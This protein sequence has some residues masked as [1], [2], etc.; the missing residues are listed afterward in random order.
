MH[1][2]INP[3]NHLGRRRIDVETVHQPRLYWK[4]QKNEWVTVSLLSAFAWPESCD[5]EAIA[6]F[7]DCM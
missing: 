2:E 4:F 1:S 3:P 7:E 5:P 6:L